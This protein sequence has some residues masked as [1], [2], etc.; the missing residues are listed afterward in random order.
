MK[1][2]WSTVTC[3]LAA[4]VLLGGTQPAL[5]ESA[6]QAQP[7]ERAKVCMLDDMVQTT[8]GIEHKVAGKTY[9]VCCPGCTKKM[10]A[11]PER[12]TKAHDPVTGQTVDKSTAPVVAYKEKAYFF[13]SQ[14]AQAA[15]T[16]DPERYVKSASGQEGEKP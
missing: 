12:Y 10:D 8:P 1:Q 3:L 5:A 16:K 2:M 4:A 9:Y 15:F 11:E 14:D 13:A 7:I 6:T